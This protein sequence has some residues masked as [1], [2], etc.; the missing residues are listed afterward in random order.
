[1]R[2]GFII[3]LVL[4][5][6]DSKAQT[7]KNTTDSLNL[8]SHPEIFWLDTAVAAQYPFI[9]LSLNNFRFYTPEAPNWKHFFRE[10][11]AMTAEKDRKLNLYHLGGSH[12]QAD[13]YTHV[14][15][16]FLQT[17]WDDLCGERGQ[18]FPFSIAGTNNP[19]NYKFRSPNKW[20][21]YRSPV[22]RPA[23]IHYGL[24]GIVATCADSIIK[25]S[26]K[27]D[28]TE[29]RSEFKSFRILHNKGTLPYSISILN[30][31]L[32]IEDIFTNETLGYTEYFLNKE[33]DSLDLEFTRTSADKNP[34]EIYGFTFLNDSPGCSYSAIGVNGAAL[35]T[36]LGNENF[37]EQLCIYP[38]DLFIFSVG[39]NDANVPYDQFDPQHYKN[40]LESL[41]QKVLR[42]NPDCAILLT[43]P[44]DSYYQKKYLNRNI[45]RQRNVI[46]ELA[47]KYKLAVWD[48]YGIM[49]EL[50][51][52]KTWQNAGLMQ[53]DLVHFTPL[54]YQLKG[55]LLTDAFLKF[56]EQM[57][58]TEKMQ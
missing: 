32:G 38:P 46:I 37:E 7:E 51:S 45:E 40:N 31:E 6:Y 44:N 58:N 35:N 52:S 26:F 18:V 39:T 34:L 12:L 47:E 29:V 20:K 19:A 10:F 25:L 9:D 28:R 57:R 4:L 14:F 11:D 53:A 22:T 27:Y 36:Y 41:I 15:R 24:S 55:K 5:S 50:G 1:M 33:I 42:C 56:L 2:V 3:V 8:Y 48:V 30:G 43:V 16:T 13:I 49:G 23:N 17:N 21:G 54:G